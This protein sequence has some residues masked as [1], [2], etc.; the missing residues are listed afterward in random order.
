MNAAGHILGRYATM[1]AILCL[2][3][4]ASD[5]RHIPAEPGNVASIP[6]RITILHTNDHHGR[7]WRNAKKEYGLAA[8]KTLIDAIRKEVRAA[9]GYALLLD[10]GDVNTGVPESDMQ[11]AEPDFRGMSRLGYDAMAVGNHEF[12]KSLPVLRK[13][14]E[15]WSGFP[16]LSANIYQDGKR[17]FEPY[18]V[19]TLGGVRLAVLG[20]TTQDTARMIDAGKFPGVAL[21]SPADEAR[22]LMPELRQRADIVVVASHIGHYTDGKHGSNA[23]GDVELARMVPGIDLIVGGHSQ[24]VVCMLQENIRNDAYEPGGPCRPDRQNGAWI[25]QAGE[26]GKFVGR[27]DF[28]Y[29]KGEFRL[30]K[31]TLIPVNLR[32]PTAVANETP[33]NALYGPEI[34][35]DQDM[36]ALLQPYQE[37][38][39]ATLSTPVGRTD[40]VFDG[41]RVQVRSRPTNLGVLV[42]TAMKEILHADF[43]LVSSGGIRDSLPAGAVTYRDILQVHPFGNQ[44]AIVTM[45]GAQVRDYISAV[46][47]K[48]PGSGAFPQ[49]S[50]LRFKMEAGM[51][52]ELSVNG[53][54][55]DPA[56]TYR[57]AI[58]SFIAK[59]GDGYPVVTTHEGYVNTGRVDAD[60]LREFIAR[61]DIIR[62]A[63]YAPE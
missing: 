14:Q 63:G 30:V 43:A 28:E 59:G 1:L 21:T 26:W 13:Q 44:I 9:G 39:A 7:F 17:M 54:E 48:Q 60:V 38:G 6:V 37:R 50:G 35:E 55:I 18:R 36:L 27:A 16:W 62:T 52:R 8:R 34:A 32:K 41:E 15:Q 23:P 49:Y 57:M 2:A 31:Y 56:A 46:A 51:L 11:H 58:N 25:V 33:A 47:A 24:N 3:A 20:L 29:S 42:T 5:P 40:G 12:D 10:G 19:F 53:Q 45:T 4:C 22:R 61:H